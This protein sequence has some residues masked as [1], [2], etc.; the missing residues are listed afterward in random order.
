MK[1]LKLRQKRKPNKSNLM[2]Q[3]GESPDPRE[4]EEDECEEDDDDDFDYIDEQL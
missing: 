3:N 4:F 1:Q 2:S